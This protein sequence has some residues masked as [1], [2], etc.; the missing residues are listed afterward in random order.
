VHDLDE[1]SSPEPA[2]V[3][4][5]LLAE[6]FIFGRIRNEQRQRARRH[7]HPI[8]VTPGSDGMSFV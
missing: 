5:E 4:F 3:P 8:Q 2:D 1:A 7:L 6:R